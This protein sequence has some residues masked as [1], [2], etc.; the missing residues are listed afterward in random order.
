MEKGKAR[1][2]LRENKVRM[3]KLLRVVEVKM[4]Q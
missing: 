3:N 2:E 1:Q 4:C